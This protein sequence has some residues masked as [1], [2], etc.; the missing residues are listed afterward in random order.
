MFRIVQVNRSESTGTEFVLLQNQG[1]MR[2]SLRGLTLMSDC[3]IATGDLGLAHVFTENEQVPPGA[4][5]LLHT[6][7][8]TPSITRCRDGII[9]R[10]YMNRPDCV[11]SPCPG[12]IHVMAPHHTFQDRRVS[13]SN[14][15][16]VEELAYASAR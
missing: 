10:A 3:A 4:F 6:G 8:G 16:A 9:Y 15:Q 12:A 1:N 13:R 14:F 11:W 7:E 2:Q 5:V